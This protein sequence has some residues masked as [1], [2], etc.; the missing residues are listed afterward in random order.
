MWSQRQVRRR[1]PPLLLRAQK[2]APARLPRPGVAVQPPAARGGRVLP[3]RRDLARDQLVARRDLDRERRAPAAAAAARADLEGRAGRPDR[4]GAGPAG[5]RRPSPCSQPAKVDASLR[6]AR[7]FAPAST[8]PP[9]R[10]LDVPDATSRRSRRAT[11]P[12]PARPRRRTRRRRAPPPRRPARADVRADDARADTDPA[13]ATA[14]PPPRDTSCSR[15]R[16]APHALAACPCPRP[17]PRT[18]IRRTCAR[19]P[20]SARGRRCSR[21]SNR[22]PTRP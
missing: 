20:R 12:V 17:R 2:H 10:A 14:A 16:R 11:T 8:S 13:G 6:G 21:S 15:P 18:S 9:K 4:R 5:R 7:A 19:S 1:R 3:V 22:A